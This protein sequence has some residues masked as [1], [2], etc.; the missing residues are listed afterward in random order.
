MILGQN[1]DVLSGEG[2]NDDGFF[3]HEHS[4]VFYFFIVKVTFPFVENVV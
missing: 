4:V 2:I 3:F 1:T